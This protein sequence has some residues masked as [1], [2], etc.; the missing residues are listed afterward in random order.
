MLARALKKLSEPKMQTITKYLLV[1][2]VNDTWKVRNKR[3]FDSLEAAWDWCDTHYKN[4]DDRLRFYI[5][6]VTVGEKNV[7]D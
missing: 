2:I 6:P 1:E 5:F 7:S 4:D 3:P